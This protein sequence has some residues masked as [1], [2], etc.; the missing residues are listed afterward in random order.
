MQ[1]TK[2]TNLAIIQFATSPSH[3]ASIIPFSFSEFVTSTHVSVVVTST[4]TNHLLKLVNETQSNSSKQQKNRLEHLKNQKVTA[5]MLKKRPYS[6]KSHKDVTLI[7]QGPK[8]G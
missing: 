7:H 8:K 3:L 4:P 5:R 6:I 2:Q 1:V